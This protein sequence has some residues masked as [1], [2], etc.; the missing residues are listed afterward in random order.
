MKFSIM[1]VPKGKDFATF[2]QSIRA[3]LSDLGPIMGWADDGQYLYDYRLTREQISAIEQTYSLAL[4]KDLELYLT[5][6][7]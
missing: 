1:G 4:P 2:E 3:V 7:D 5:C 6:I